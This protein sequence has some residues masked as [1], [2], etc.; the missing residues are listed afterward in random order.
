M[1]ALKL[2]TRGADLFMT[3]GLN[4]HIAFVGHWQKGKERALNAGWFFMQAREQVKDGD[5]E[6]YVEIF[7]DSRCKKING[8]QPLTYRTVR[9]Y[10]QLTL[11]ALEWAKAEHPGISKPEKLLEFAIKMVMQSPKPLVALCR[12]LGHM[13]KFGEYDE[14]KYALN[15]RLKGSDQIEFEFD[16]VMAP[17]DMLARLADPKISFRYPEGRDELEY[18]TEVETKLETALRL[19]REVKKNGR[20]ISV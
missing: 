14:V 4:A 18:M 15:K 16:K 20:V 9:F 8:N 3:E 19:I 11:E 5:W 7:C 13:R 10:T 17:L 1:S 2:P 6:T 12:E